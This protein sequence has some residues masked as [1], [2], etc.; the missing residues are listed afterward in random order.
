MQIR[1]A[2]S[3]QRKYWHNIFEWPSLLAPLAKSPKH[4][5][6]ENYF[7]AAV[8]HPCAN[9]LWVIS[10]LFYELLPTGRLHVG[11]TCHLL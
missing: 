11:D 8:P 5:L 1:Q 3:C 7:G 10:V 9:L 2:I 6:F 4:T